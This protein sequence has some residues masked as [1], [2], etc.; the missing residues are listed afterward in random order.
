MAISSPGIGSNLD[1]NGIVSKLMAVEAAPLNQL[2]NKIASFNAKLSALGTLSGAVSAFQGSLSSLTSVSSF[3]A[4]NAVSNNTDV[5]VG[6]ATSKAVAGVYSV[7]VTQMAQAQSLSSTGKASTTAAIGLGNKTTVSF[8]L[9]SITGGSYGM[10]GVALPASTLTGGIANGA[11]TINGTAIA[12]SGATKSARALA[13]A[14]NLQNTTTG[15]TA[16]AQPAVSSATLFAG[17]GAIDTSGGG[18]YALTVAGIKIGEQA[19]GLAPGDTGA[20]NATAIDD[21]LGGSNSTT[22][23]LAAAG[24]TVSGKAALGT[25]QFTATDG[26]NLTIAEN[27]TGSVTGGIGKA[28]L[29]PNGGSSTTTS[30]GITLASSSASPITIA[31]T[32]PAAAGLTAG[33]GGSYAGAGFSQDANAISGTVVIDSTNNSM[34]GIRDAINKANLGVTATIV[35]DGSANPNHLVLTSTKTG[36]ASAMKIS[37]TGENG[38]PADADLEALLAYDPAGLQNMKQNTAAQSTL[39]NVNG[40]PVTSQTNSVADAIQGVTLTVGSVGQ[41]NLHVAKNTDAVKTGVNAFV[42]AYNDLNSAI[43]QATAYD[44]ET[45]KGGPLLGE[46]TVQTLQSQIRKQLATAVTGT[47]GSLTTLGQVGISFQKDGTLALDSGKLDKAIKDNFDGIAGLFAAVGKT[48]DSLVSFSSSTANT[49]PGDYALYV[50]QVATQGKVTSDAVVGPTTTIAADTKWAVTLNQTDPATPSRTQT[51]SLAA[52]TY[53]PAQLATLI[54]SAI[55]G[56]SGFSSNNLSV[57]ASIGDDGKLS[58]TSVQYGSVSKIALSTENGTPVSAIFGAASSGDGQDVAGT[59]GGQP[60]KGSG[61]FLTGAAGSAVDGMK[62][63]I[64]G[65][66]PG[67]R[68]T[69]GFT[70]GYAYQLNNLASSFLGAKGLITSRTDGINATIKD[71]GKRKEVFN[72]R[73]VDIEKRYRAQYTALDTAIAS[74]SATQSFLT[75]QL[76]ALSAQTS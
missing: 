14:I 1:V 20:L 25:L 7:N 55:N 37:L 2:D 27:V 22:A 26:S 43:K 49:K 76:A 33:T 13:E 29:A 3:Q 67:D 74:M 24:I 11:L 48:S 35:S 70:Q 71:I 6:T 17:F 28:T 21:V 23:A 31:G 15:V 44:P 59:I 12:T 34:Q 32:N 10:S 65:G 54:Q 19:D 40:I 53:T 16:T 62:I 72:E 42:K 45:K 47:S 57:N 51:I 41:A 36:A 64:T 50:S 5:M 30:S 46:S 69:V 8:Q 38:A 60:A 58:V 73:L 68:G 52:G 9:G 63:E 66:L 56:A 61:Q 39:L 4:N 18:T 75:Q